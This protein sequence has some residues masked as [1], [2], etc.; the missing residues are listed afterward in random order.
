MAVLGIPGI[1][2][3][4]VAAAYAFSRR[5][6]FDAVFWIQV[7]TT[8]KLEDGFAQIARKLNLKK[9]N[10]EELFDAVAAREETKGWLSNPKKVVNQ[11]KDLI[12]QVDATWLLIL[13]N[14]DE[15]SFLADYWPVFGTGSVLVTS[16]KSK[17]S[18]EIAITETAAALRPLQVEQ[19]EPFTVEDGAQLIRNWTNSHEPDQIERSRRIAEILGGIPLALLQCAE[20]VKD[21]ELTFGHFL[22]WHKR[23]QERGDL[24]SDFE[25][26]RDNI[27]ARGSI[28]TRWT[29]KT[30]S[31]GAKALID[32]FSFLD[33]DSIQDE[34]L[35][36]SLDNIDPG[37]L[38]SDFPRTYKQMIPARK[39][40]TDR[41]FVKFDRG[42]WRIH[43][44]VQVVFRFYMNQQRMQEVFTSTIALVHHFW[45]PEYHKGRSHSIARWRKYNQLHNH[46][47]SISKLYCELF[48]RGFLSPS[49]QLARLLFQCAWYASTRLL[50]CRH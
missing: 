26:P 25:T 18:F 48:R 21:D 43:R 11:S 44:S 30:M 17:Y 49:V 27:P 3:S 28:A 41:P 14:A 12:A 32:I 23:Q 31:P 4:E 39:E 15:P 9:C 46:L 13:D 20:M 6:R 50:L 10:D 33:P 8:M 45:E 37:L 42:E 19:L 5:S 22:D 29:M 40:L 7:D 35:V 24:I 2:K 16:N 1:G 38:L 36:Q 34:I 47:I